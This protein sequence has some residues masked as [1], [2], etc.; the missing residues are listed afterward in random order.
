MSDGSM[1][2]P[3]SPGPKAQQQRSFPR[4]RHLALHAP[5]GVV[6]SDS[7]KPAGPVP[8]DLTEEQVEAA[9]IAAVLET[10]KPDPQWF[11]A[12]VSNNPSAA[13]IWQSMQGNGE[14][15]L[16]WFPESREP[17]LIYAG[18]A[19]GDYY[20][21]VAIHYDT[22]SVSTKIVSSRGL[23]QTQTQ[24]HRGVVPWVRRRKDRIG[25]ALGMMAISQSHKTDPVKTP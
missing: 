14:V 23:G 24:I 10:P 9:I 19:Q 15:D 8:P 3:P 6:Q 2:R 11:N 21:H 17:G 7:S 1:E 4:R 12:F 20:L 13:G 16:G 22:T 5:G 18:Y 25:R